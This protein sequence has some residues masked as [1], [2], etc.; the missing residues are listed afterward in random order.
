VPLDLA[1]EH[2]EQVP[3]L[4]LLEILDDLLELIEEDEDASLSA[5]GKCLR[6]SRCASSLVESRLIQ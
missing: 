3:R 4:T 1:A 6:R 2:A 5:S